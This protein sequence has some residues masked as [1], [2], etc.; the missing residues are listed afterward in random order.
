M[1]N[2]R[3]LRHL[4]TDQRYM[5]AMSRESKAMCGIQ[6]DAI[7]AC[8]ARL[9]TTLLHIARDYGEQF[10]YLSVLPYCE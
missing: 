10:L 4:T 8:A 9:T 6:S 7:N 2:V 3:N 1:T 5:D